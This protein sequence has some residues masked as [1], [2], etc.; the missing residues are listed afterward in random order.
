MRAGA[1]EADVSLEF[2]NMPPFER[3]QKSQ[4]NVPPSLSLV[5]ILFVASTSLK[6]DLILLSEKRKLLMFVPFA[7]RFCPVFGWVMYV[8]SGPREYQG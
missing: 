4:A 5:I 3:G 7:V 6:Y 8:P 2:G 1:N